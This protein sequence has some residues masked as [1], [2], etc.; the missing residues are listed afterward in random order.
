MAQYSLMRAGVCGR[1]VRPVGAFRRLDEPR[2]HPPRSAVQTA[3]AGQSRPAR[4]VTRSPKTASTT[5]GALGSWS[6]RRSELFEGA[7]QLGAVSYHVPALA[8]AVHQ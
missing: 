3:D 1:T 2:R 4:P 8:F 6:D 7:D 5:T